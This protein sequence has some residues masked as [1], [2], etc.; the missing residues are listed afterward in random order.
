MSDKDTGRADRGQGQVK[1]GKALEEARG[2]IVLP[3]QTA[4][5]DITNHAGGRPTGGGGSQGDS[6]P[7]GSGSDSE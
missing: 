6:A 2:S 5:I 3:I 1:E 4:P 7:S